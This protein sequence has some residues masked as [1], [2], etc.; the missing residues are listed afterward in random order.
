MRNILVAIFAVL[1]LQIGIAQA[2]DT[3]AAKTEKV[4]Y[5][6]VTAKPVE[7]SL[8]AQLDLPDDTAM[9]VVTVDPKGPAAADLKPNDVLVKLDDQILIDVHQF[10]TLVRLHKPGDSVTLSIIRQAKPIQV[11]IKL[12]EKEVATAS[13]TAS[14]PDHTTDANT[15]NLPDENAHSPFDV[16]VPLGPNSQVAMAFSDGTYSASV[17]TDAM[18]RRHMTVKDTG[19][20]VVASGPVNTEE[21]WDKFAPEIRQHLEIM[22]K[23]LKLKSK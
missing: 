5:L 3:D 18:G 8:R 11:T 17:K 10:V 4:A 2:A 9:T 19:D 20:R 22:H 6:G 23:A 21:E 12:G 1:M 16:Q 14:D 7:A 13:A 15:P